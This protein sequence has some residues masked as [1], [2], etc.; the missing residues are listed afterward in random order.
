[1]EVVLECLTPNEHWSD[2]ASNVEFRL[3]AA[4]PGAQSAPRK[5][6]VKSRL[7]NL[8][9]ESNIGRPTVPGSSHRV[10]PTPR[11][12]QAKSFLGVSGTRSQAASKFGPPQSLNEI[13]EEADGL[14][15]E[16]D[17]DA[18][19]IGIN[20]GGG[21]KLGFNGSDEEGGF[22]T[23][24]QSPL[25]RKR[26]RGTLSDDNH[27]ERGA[28]KLSLMSDDEGTPTELKSLS[29]DGGNHEDEGDL[30]PGYHDSDM[31]EFD[32][33]PLFPPSDDEGDVEPMPAA[34]Q[35]SSKFQTKIG[36]AFGGGN[37]RRQPK[38]EVP[39]DDK[40][41]L[42]PPSDEE[43]DLTDFVLTDDEDVAK[44]VPAAP[45][46]SSKF[47]AKQGFDIGGVN[48]SV[49][50]KPEV[51]KGNKQPFFRPSNDEDNIKRMPP[52]A[53]TKTSKF[54]MKRKGLGGMNQSV[55]GGVDE[56]IDGFP[57]VINKNPFCP[58]LEEC[59]DDSGLFVQRFCEVNRRATHSRYSQRPCMT[60]S[61]SHYARTFVQEDRLGTLISFLFQ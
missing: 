31:D 10:E 58:D 7:G 3:A 59:E 53:P 36:L 18:T 45:Q 27:S 1:M 52:P 46:K 48:R 8:G 4:P 5:A 60:V 39:K 28:G 20:S 9:Y 56:S 35:K 23:D 51:P 29:S 13:G 30:A 6:P 55:G 32:K 61:E 50:P 42:F 49:Q 2:C 40:P 12:H 24:D 22:G 19:A 43:D 44:P 16:Q 47:Q 26:M 57:K 41:P 54:Q 37:Q 17:M 14:S 34:S 38:P 11:K 15:P 21:G 25:N 33:P